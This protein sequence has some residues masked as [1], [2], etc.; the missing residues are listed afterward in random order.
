VRRILRLRTGNSVH[1]G[2]GEEHSPP[3]VSKESWRGVLFDDDASKTYFKKM[4]SSEW[5]QMKNRR[6]YIIEG[7]KK[8]IT[9]WLEG[10]LK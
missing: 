4:L 2:N 8:S 1:T 9:M 6:K 7:F 3:A 10:V 5:L